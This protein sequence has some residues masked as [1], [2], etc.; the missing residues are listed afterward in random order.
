MGGAAYSG[1]SPFNAAFPNGL[2]KSQALVDTIELNHIQQW[3]DNV[4]SAHAGVLGSVFSGTPAQIA[5]SLHQQIENEL[6]AYPNM[7]AAG[8][9]P[10]IDVSD[11]G[12]GHAMLVYDL[13]DLGG[14]AYKIDVIDPNVQFTANEK[15]NTADH[16]NRQTMSAI[17]IDPNADP[18]ANEWVYPFLQ[19]KDKTTNWHGVLD[20]KTL[21]VQPEGSTYD[22]QPKLPGLSSLPSLIMLA[23]GGSQLDQVTDAK[24]RHL[25]DADGETKSGSGAIPGGAAIP[26]T[27]AA[28]G[29]NPI[30]YVPITGDYTISSER[31]GSSP[32][33]LTAV[34]HGF[35]AAATIAGGGAFQRRGA[36]APVDDRLKVAG[37]T[38][39]ATLSP[40]AAG[41]ETLTLAARTRG[42]VLTVALE[43]HGTKGSSDSAKLAANGSIE[44]GHTGGAVTRTLTLAYGGG[45]ALP[46]AGKVTGLKLGAG[47]RL[48]VHVADWA[49]LRGVTVVRRH[50]GHTSRSTL[51]VRP[52]KAKLL[53]AI[54]LNARASGR[55]L[56][57]SA[58]LTHRGRLGWTTAGV[59]FVVARGKHVVART[60]IPLTPAQLSNRAGMVVW[61]L[62]KS[63][64]KGRYRI[65]AIVTASALGSN[66]V[67]QNDLR[68]TRTH[69]R[70]K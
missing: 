14:G 45:S 39:T 18:K 57:V 56:T 35:V 32:G 13:E 27:D 68:T 22:Q 29:P 55:R 19:E 63:L 64:A 1:Y 6:K 44:L 69:T 54:K 10:I 60:T 38:H 34:G 11:E 61:K 50:G 51:H 41:T 46:T 62:P 3:D 25:I 42:H 58:R 31:P 30:G 48:V 8:R 7:P 36:A 43:G 15:T 59:S 33:R 12:A 28:E 47:E 53:G 37:S 67:A 23:S 20:G 2:D 26:P 9:A 4:L 21:W 49:H 17:T 24:G 66:G 16:T 65:V 70:I 40:G 5:A 52:A